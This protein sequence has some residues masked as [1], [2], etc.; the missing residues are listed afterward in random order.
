MAK[1]YAEV[2]SDKHGRVASKGGDEYITVNVSNGNIRVF[3]ITF[4]DDGERR[5]TLEIMSYAYGPGQTRVV[6]YMGEMFEARTQ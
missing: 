4:R 6:E 5:G 1:L 2:A 3:E